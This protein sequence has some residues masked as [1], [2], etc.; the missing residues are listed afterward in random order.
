[1]VKGSSTLLGTLINCG[2]CKAFY[3]GNLIDLMWVNGGGDKGKM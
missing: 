2:G 3:K 1:M